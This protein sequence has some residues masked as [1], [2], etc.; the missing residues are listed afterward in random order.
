LQLATDIIS[1]PS[2]RGSAA[3]FVAAVFQSIPGGSWRYFAKVLGDCLAIRAENGD[4]LLSV[5]IANGA[6]DFAKTILDD[7][8]FELARQDP[9]RCIAAVAYGRDSGILNRIRDLDFNAPLPHGVNGFPDRGPPPRARW[10]R[11]RAVV[12]TEPARLRAGVPLLLAMPRPAVEH[13]RLDHDRRGKHGQT[14]IFQ[15]WVHGCRSKLATG[16][17]VNA[18]DRHGNT[19]LG[20]GMVANP[21]SPTLWALGRLW[22]FGIRNEN[23]DAVWDLVNAR[24]KRA[25]GGENRRQNRLAEKAGIS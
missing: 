25:P 1:H 11:G 10:L 24:L 22:D 6:A 20:C 19:A 13:L 18:V 4:T 7:P 15:D 9:A 2:F 12:A 14:V 17:R 8:A 21:K 3:E 5:A 23:G 16:D